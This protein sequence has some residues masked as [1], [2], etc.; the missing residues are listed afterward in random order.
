MSYN[1]DESNEGPKN[2]ILKA[3][4]ELNTNWEEFKHINDQKIEKLEKGDESRAKELDIV[5]DRINVAM[6]KTSKKISELSVEFEKTKN[7]LE[8]AEALLERPNNGT[9]EEKA[10]KKHLQL[11]VKWVRSG[12][13]DLKVESEMSDLVKHM[14]TKTDS[15][16][17]GT[18]DQGGSG[19]PAI[20]GQT[21]ENLVLKQSEI[22]ANV[23]QV[24]AGSSYSE[25]V[26]IAGA[27][28]GWA[29]E[30]GG[31]SQ[32]ATPNLRKVTPTHGGL[33][34]FP[35]VSTWSLEDIFFDVVNWVEQDASETMAVTLST[36]IYSG[37]GSSKPTGITHTAPVA[38]D[39]YA[40]PLRAA[41]AYEYLPLSNS[42]ITFNADDIITLQYLLR[43]RYQ[44]GAKFAMNSTTVGAV[45]K[46]KDTTNQYLWQPSYQVGAPSMILGKPI[47]I[48]EDLGA[49][50][51]GNAFPV[52]YGDFT[53][54]YLLTKIGGMTMIRDNVTT[55]GYV[56]FLMEQRY[57]G[58]ILNN[59]A[60]KLLKIAAS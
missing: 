26:T 20:I 59:D 25:L 4:D 15:V 41:A 45:R 14:Q 43:P 27:N 54:G 32:S 11:W 36:A 56:N 23:K 7:R 3:I 37:D 18:A 16:L 21:I 10:E 33:Y 51:S 52:A 17:I 53:R 13:K 31:R 57:G 35:K 55:P 34:A 22:V 40:S 6:D 58:I 2:P 1:A 38:T 60:V 50:T 28:G 49:T 24:T 44:T 29:T 48:W 47:F 12:M 39:D 5:T 46:L 9:V 30:T 19:V 42:P 8:M